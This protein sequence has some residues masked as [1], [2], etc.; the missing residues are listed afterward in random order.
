MLNVWNIRGMRQL[1]PCRFADSHLICCLT[2]SSARL[3]VDDWRME[4]R[5]GRSLAKNIKNGKDW[6]QKMVSGED[7]HGGFLKSGYPQSSSISRQDFPL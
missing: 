7:L 6:N 5:E 1:D 4:G 3:S 2:L